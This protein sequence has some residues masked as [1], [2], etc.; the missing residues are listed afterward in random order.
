MD[1]VFG[2]FAG[3]LTASDRHRAINIL[4]VVTGTEAVEA[5]PDFHAAIAADPETIGI[6]ISGTGSKVASRT[7]AGVVK[8]GGG[9]LYLGDLGSAADIGRRSI[10]AT[11][12]RP[13]AKKPRTSF[14]GRWLIFLARM[15][16]IR[17]LRRCIG[18]LRQ[19]RSWRGLPERCL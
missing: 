18:L 5:Q 2:G 9:G 19:Q 6:V 1:F 17:W 10:H 4:N 13:A 11:T 16:P 15:N 12:S 7:R 8:S 14:G 3:L